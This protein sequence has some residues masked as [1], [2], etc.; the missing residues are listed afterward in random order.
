MN[1]DEILK[2][3]QKENPKND[4]RELFIQTKG[5]S[6]GMIASS[7]MF[8]FLALVKTF[9]GEAIYDILAMYEVSMIALYIYKYKMEK[10]KKDLFLAIC[11]GMTTIINLYLA[12]WRH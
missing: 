7:V 4:E 10:K 5:Y 11:W 2:M 8:V 3:A 6:Y 9:R 1:R 12:I